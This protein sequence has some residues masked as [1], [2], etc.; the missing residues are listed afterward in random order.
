MKI[1][2]LIDEL[3]TAKVRFGDVECLVEV[4]IEDCVAL[5]PVDELNY[6]DREV[7]GKSVSLIC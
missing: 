3:E 7:F 2:K 6:E 5:M 4:I 1:Q